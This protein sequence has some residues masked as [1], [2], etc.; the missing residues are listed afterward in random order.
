MQATAPDPLPPAV[1]LMR[2]GCVPV[3]CLLLSNVMEQKRFALKRLFETV[4]RELERIP[5]K[6]FAL[7]RLTRYIKGAEKPS[8]ETLDRISLLVGFQSWESFQKALHGN[9][10]SEENYGVASGGNGG[11]DGDAPDEGKAHRTGE[12]AD[13]GE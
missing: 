6:V 10:D 4:E 2:S 13:S 11:G 5:A 7:D 8:R 3:S 9:T 12:G 1:M